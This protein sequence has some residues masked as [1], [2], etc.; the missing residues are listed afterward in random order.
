LIQ[1]DIKLS[2][3]C[4]KTPIQLAIIDKMNDD[5]LINKKFHILQRNKIIRDSERFIYKE[6]GNRI[7]DSLEGLN[8]SIEKCLEIGFSSNNI[9]KYILNRSKNINYSVLDISKDLLI[10]LPKSV[11]SFC[12]DHDK[13]TLKK[14]QFNLIIS[15][16]YLHLTNNIDKL[17]CNINLSL[18]NNGFFIASIPSNNNLI[19]LKNVM[20]A[21]DL[22]LYGGAYRRFQDNLSIQ[23]I[24]KLLKKN[25]FKDILI[26]IDTLNFQYKNFQKL[27]SDIKNLGNSYV[28]IDRK[29]KFENKQYF[30]KA[31]EIYWK[32]FSK[33]NKL[34][35][36]IKIIYFSGWKV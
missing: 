32:K 34:N 30:K 6:I 7:N 20:L 31:E 11:N 23:S 13:W 25:N 12:I 8:L 2:I 9:Y 36:T 4:I 1:S 14:N 5:Q 26:D 21:T 35:L 17:L 19:E 29:K 22:K 27:L 18:K 33:N 15:N 28:F 10:S 3:S 24:S 16:F